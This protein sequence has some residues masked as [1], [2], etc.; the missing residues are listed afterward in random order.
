MECEFCKHI[1]T[2]KSILNMHKKTAKYCIILQNKNTALFICEFCNK[3]FAQNKNLDY[4][5]NICKKHKEHKENLHNIKNNNDKETYEKKIHDLELEIK[6][7]KE[8]YENVVKQYET[9]IKNITDNYNK[10]I[11]EQQQIYH[12]T[13]NKHKNDMI[14]ILNNKS[15]K[16]ID[17]AIKKPT[18]ITQINN[19]IEK[20]EILTYKHMEEQVQNLTTEHVEK[21]IAGYVD[22]ALKNVFKD[23]LA[24]SD[25][26]RKI[27]KYK[28]DKDTVVTDSGMRIITPLFFKSISS[29]NIELK[30]EIIHKIPDYI[31]GKIKSLM[32]EKIKK[33]ADMVQESSKG[34]K[35]NLSTG[36]TE[37]ICSK[38]SNIGGILLEKNSTSLITDKKE[39]QWN[40][41][42]DKYF[43]DLLKDE[44]NSTPEP[45]PYQMIIENSETDKSENDEES[46]SEN[47]REK[48]K[49][50]NHNEYLYEDD[51][52]D[53]D[54][55]E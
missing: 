5:L 29:K 31:T 13:E 50:E 21:G 25:Y 32:I 3:E 55:D 12:D 46:D 42:D 33:T 38:I 10:K 16:Y 15:E 27:V 19:K 7:N 49:L 39:D 4:H 2:S 8:K 48:E 28:T 1:F 22:Y 30:N 53:K 6:N 40:S 26:S 18:N 23:K 35:T 44:P 11:L 51:D 47:E 37:L 54:E 34:I 36:F 17:I 41:D 43:E 9:E 24:C 14:Q 52:I 45:Y 20:L